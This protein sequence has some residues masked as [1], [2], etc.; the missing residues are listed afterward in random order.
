MRS[1]RSMPE[2][3][4]AWAMKTNMN[5]MRQV[6]LRTK[7]VLNP[8]FQGEECARP[9]MGNLSGLWPAVWTTR[10][11]I[12][13][14]RLVIVFQTAPLRLLSLTD[15]SYDNFRNIPVVWARYLTPPMHPDPL[16]NCRAIRPAAWRRNLSLQPCERY[17]RPPPDGH[18]SSRGHRHTASPS[19]LAHRAQR[20]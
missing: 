15:K 18:P 5:L 20:D 4:R 17:P 1:S 12:L 16:T 3:C 10:G 2:S 9:M 6:G 13:C 11:P 14:S 8:M 19:D 7:D